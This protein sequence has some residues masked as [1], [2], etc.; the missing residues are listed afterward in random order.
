[1][2]LLL[3]D[4]GVEV[5]HLE[6]LGVDGRIIENGFSRIEVGR[7]GLNLNWSGSG[8]GQVASAFGSHKMGG[9]S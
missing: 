1:M 3:V 8:Q 4:V 2:C 5:G 9:I 7:H 6:D